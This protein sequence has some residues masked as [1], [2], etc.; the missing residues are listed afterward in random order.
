MKVLGIDPGLAATGVGV[1][2]GHGPHIDGHAFGIIRTC[3]RTSLPDR[4][5]HIHGQ[6][7]DLLAEER[8]DLM[9]V[10]DVF[11]LDRY[12][13]SGIQLGH[14]TGVIFLAGAQAGVPVA[15]VAVREAKGVLTGHGGADKAHLERAV[16]SFLNRT[17]PIRPAHAAD[18]LALAII[19][20]LRHSDGLPR[21]TGRAAAPPLQRIQ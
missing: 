7:S 21:P 12:P 19:G 9:V 1:V 13:R 2:W 17:A 4:L 11:S 14:V 3:A 18:A 10:E 6:V 15:E 16:R 20:L 8:P 5:N